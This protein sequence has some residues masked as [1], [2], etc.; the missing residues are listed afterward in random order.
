M[1]VR[2]MMMDVRWMMMDVRWYCKDSI[3]TQKVEGCHRFPWN[4]G[5]RW[6]QVTITAAVAWMFRPLRRTLSGGSMSTRSVIWIRSTTTCE[7]VQNLGDVNCIENRLEDANHYFVYHVLVMEFPWPVD[8]MKVWGLQSCS[9]WHV[10]TTRTA[11]AS[12][13]TSISQQHGASVTV[14]PFALPRIFLI[15]STGLLMAL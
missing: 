10:P 3:A 1:D 5:P 8:S 2:W 12:A 7:P 6:P 9:T 11:L 15:S 13:L 14:Q 4:S